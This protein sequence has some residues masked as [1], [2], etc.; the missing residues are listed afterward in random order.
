MNLLASFSTYATLLI[1]ITQ[2]CVSY[3]HDAS[4]IQRNAA[5][6][7]LEATVTLRISKHLVGTEKEGQWCVIQIEDC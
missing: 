5:E 7:Q 1:H 3:N 6:A 4:F 2:C